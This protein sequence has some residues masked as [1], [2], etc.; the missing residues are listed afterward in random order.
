MIGEFLRKLTVALDRSDVPY[1]LTGSL[2]SSMY[3]VPRATNDVD[4]VISPSRQQLASLLQFLKRLGLILQEEQAFEAFARGTMFNAVDL[5]NSWKADFILRK[6][7]EFSLSEFSRRES[8]EVAG[9]HLTLASPED[10]VIAKL[11]WAKASNSE[12]QIQDA[13]GVL[14]MQAD[15]LNVAYVEQWVR[16]LGLEVQW[17]EAK[18][19]AG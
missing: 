8:H 11:E 9:I 10:V 4:L 19:L 17:L 3:G 14:R 7:R 12:Q 6:T 16:E 15:R 5:Q 1:M 18:R 13:A 2:A